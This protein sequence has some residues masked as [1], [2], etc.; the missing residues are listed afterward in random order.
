MASCAST[1]GCHAGMKDQHECFCMINKNL[2]NV[3][4][5]RYMVKFYSTMRLSCFRLDIGQY[6]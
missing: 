5:I 6:Q 2:L 4:F 3:S 1:E